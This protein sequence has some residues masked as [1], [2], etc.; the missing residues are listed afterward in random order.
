METYYLELQQQAEEK[1]ARREADWRNGAIVYQVLVDRFAP[2]ADLEAKREHY[3]TPKRILPWTQEP[4]RGKY[5]PELHIWAHEIDFWG[6]DLPSLQARLGYLEDLQVDVLYLNPIHAAFTNHKYDA[7]DFMQIS[8]EYG[9]WDDLLALIQQTHQAEMKIVLDGVFNHVGRQSALFQRAC[10][11]VGDPGHGWFTF[12]SECSQGVRLWAHAHNLPELNFENPAVRDFI[13][14]AEDSVVRTYLRAG[15]DGWRLDTA[16]ELGYQVLHE[17]TSNAH[18]E[19]AGSLV[20][21]EIWNY[22]QHWMPALDG[23]MNFT[24]RQ[25]ILD[26]LAGKLAP[27]LANEMLATVIEDAGVEAMLKSWILLD[28]HDVRRI[29][30]VLPDSADQALAQVLQFTLP[31]APNLYYGSELGMAGGDD[32]ANRAPMRWDLVRD[33]NPT[34]RRTRQLI[35]LRRSARA[36]RIGDFRRLPAG[37]LI[38]FER[39]TEKVAETLVVLVNP[40]GQ[41][42]SDKVLV[43]DSRLMNA[44][45][46]QNLLDR[47]E[48]FMLHSGLLEVRLPAKSAAILKPFTDFVDGYSP[49]KRID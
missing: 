7:L 30:N 49:Y 45:R 20:V 19:K 3:P 10:T 43:P 44:T 23:V 32:P 37:N 26:T 16:F 46:M 22:P 28:N 1:F 8:P 40:T 25:I 13:Y 42:V 6:G 48:E 31:G 27:S 12:D 11:G 21:G 9:S 2:P 36:L 29:A 15:I 18:Q 35:D 17:L 47:Q 4:Q 38:A 5:L 24:V 34:Y 39:F 41:A 14:R 33:D